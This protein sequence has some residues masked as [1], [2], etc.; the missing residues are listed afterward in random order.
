MGKSSKA[1][2]SKASVSEA[3]TSSDSYNPESELVIVTSPEGSMKPPRTRQPS[4]SPAK[5]IQLSK[6]DGNRPSKTRSRIS[7]KSK[8]SS[9]KK[10]GG[11]KLVTQGAIHP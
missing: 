7:A 2:S 9:A 11:V 4:E 10:K 8:A 5:S 3:E 6:G 1:T